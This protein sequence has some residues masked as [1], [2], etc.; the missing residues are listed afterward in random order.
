LISRGPLRIAANLGADPVEIPL[1]A[2]AATLLA[3]STPD[4][5]AESG[6]LSLPPAAFAVAETGT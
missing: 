2:P 4:I 5:T 6:T 3:A 1:G